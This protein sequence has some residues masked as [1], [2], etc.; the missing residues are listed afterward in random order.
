MYSRIV[1]SPRTFTDMYCVG[2]PYLITNFLESGVYASARP[3]VV[4]SGLS[5]RATKQRV[6]LI[7]GPAVGASY[8]GQGQ[9]SLS[10]PCRVDG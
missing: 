6:Q 7:F 4:G 2:G 8:S 3:L 10:E 5:L 1:P 9:N